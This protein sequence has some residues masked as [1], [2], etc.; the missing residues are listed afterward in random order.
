MIR[1]SFIDDEAD[2]IIGVS[3]LVDILVD[4][5]GIE[6]FDD[7]VIEFAEFLAGILIDHD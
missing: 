4:L 2:K 1:W 6:C 7:R 5:T 3:D